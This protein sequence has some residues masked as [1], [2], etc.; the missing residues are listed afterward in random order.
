ML[1][2]RM[3][4]YLM[5]SAAQRESPS[6]SGHRQMSRE[7]SLKGSGV[8]VISDAERKRCM[9]SMNISEDEEDEEAGESRHGHVDT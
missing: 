8:S 3:G 4:K 2:M 1:N 6:Q 5:G 7:R 9:W